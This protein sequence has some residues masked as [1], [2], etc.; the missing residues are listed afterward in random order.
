MSM[1]P[2]AFDTTDPLWTR[3]SACGCAV[4]ANLDFKREVSHS[5]KRQR[6]VLDRGVDTTA[7]AHICG[8]D[9]TVPS[10]LPRSSYQRCLIEL[11]F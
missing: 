2:V 1:S 9:G 8:V 7:T 6:A 11:R 5:G 3:V 4:R 10:L